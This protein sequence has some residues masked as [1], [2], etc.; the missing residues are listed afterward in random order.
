VHHL[1][2]DENGNDKKHNQPTNQPVI[3]PHGLTLPTGPHNLRDS[4]LHTHSHSPEPHGVRHTP[5]HIHSHQ[6]APLSTSPP[7]PCPHLMP[8]FPT[9]SHA[10][11]C[12]VQAHRQQTPATHI[13]CMLFLLS[14]P[15]S[16][17]RRPQ[18]CRI[19]QGQIDCV[20][21]WGP[22]VVVPTGLV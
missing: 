5:S 4:Q 13:T 8:C 16:S 22:P 2:E 21:P 20:S 7:F 1:N 12:H 14:S 11:W 10:H 17:H 6:K 9:P 19:P 18:H 3:T 15:L